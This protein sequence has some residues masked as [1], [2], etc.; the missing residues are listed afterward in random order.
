[1]KRWLH[2]QVNC[3]YHPL[4]PYLHIIYNRVFILF[5]SNKI[6]NPWIHLWL[7][8]TK[9]EL[10]FALLCTH[11]WQDILNSCCVPAWKFKVK[12][13]YFFQ[14]YVANLPTTFMVKYFSYI[15]SPVLKKLSYRQN[16][17]VFNG[18][19]SGFSSNSL[20]VT[21]Q[22]EKWFATSFCKMFHS[23][24]SQS[25]IYCRTNILFIDLKTTESMKS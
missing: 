23:L 9:K 17:Y 2:V 1:M 14:R 6:N 4:K 16:I 22:S 8:Y 13:T 3:H 12:Q 19:A 5:D 25:L 11:V 10:Y 15:C 20:S 24:L 18:S 21:F 7:N